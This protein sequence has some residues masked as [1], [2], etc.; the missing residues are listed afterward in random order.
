MRTVKMFRISGMN[1]YYGY[2]SLYFWPENDPDKMLY[3][4]PL[5]KEEACEFGSRDEAL[6]SIRLL[7]KQ[8]LYFEEYGFRIEEFT[9]EVDEETFAG[10]V[11]PNG[12]FVYVPYMQHNNWAWLVYGKC[13]DDFMFEN[14]CCEITSNGTDKTKKIIVLPFD[15]A[16]LLQIMPTEAQAKAI[17]DMELPLTTTGKSI[18]EEALR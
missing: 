12:E 14:K 1:G 15:P 10:F 7:K 9:K 6:C 4:G 3:F 16:T 13:K 17:L 18:V 2:G 5:E 8:L 11:Y